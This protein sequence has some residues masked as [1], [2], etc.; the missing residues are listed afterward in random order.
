MRKRTAPRARTG[1]T[2]S[3]A[4]VRFSLPTGAAPMAAK[5]RPTND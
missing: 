5:N 1:P 3:I 2:T 4:T